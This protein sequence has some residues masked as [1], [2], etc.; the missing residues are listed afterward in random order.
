[1]S[2]GPCKPPGLIE[3]KESSR[4]QKSPSPVITDPVPTSL[5][6]ICQTS[7]SRLIV[8]HLYCIIPPSC[9]LFLS[10]SQPSKPH[11]DLSHRLQVRQ[12]SVQ[13]PR[14]IE[15]GM[16]CSICHCPS[17]RDW[18]IGCM[19]VHE[20]MRCGSWQPA[21]TAAQRPPGVSVTVGSWQRSWSY[22]QLALRY[23]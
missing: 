10:A 6:C 16:G 1:M 7:P 4:S 3:K 18:M 15:S 5:H 13:C 19:S 12:L 14:R 2:L 22:A 11:L 8:I 20:R 23:G 21:R 9:F 17:S